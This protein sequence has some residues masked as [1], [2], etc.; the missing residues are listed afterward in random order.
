MAGQQRLIPVLYQDAEMPPMLASQARI[1]L[2]VLVVVGPAPPMVVQ[3]SYVPQPPAQSLTMIQMRSN[4]P[5]ATLWRMV[6][7]G[8]R[9]VRGY[10]GVWYSHYENWES[11]CRMPC[12]V[13]APS[14]GLYGIRGLRINWSRPFVLPGGPVA[15]LDV[16]AGHTGVRSGGVVMTTFGGIALVLGTIF[17]PISFA[18][19]N[20]SG[21]PAPGMLGGGLAMLGLGSALMTGGIAVL[22]PAS[23]GTPRCS[24]R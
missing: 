16:D 10:R 21:G 11:V 13:A 19:G 1:S 8:H 18:V 14:D 3:D 23:I 6:G 17:T 12:G 9:M 20:G 15:M 5:G 22:R 4:D 2:S 7:E 24:H